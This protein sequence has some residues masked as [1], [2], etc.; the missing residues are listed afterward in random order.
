MNHETLEIRC[1]NS[2]WLMIYGLKCILAVSYT[3]LD[4]A[5]PDIYSMYNKYALT[6]ISQVLVSYFYFPKILNSIIEIHLNIYPIYLFD[7]ELID[8]KW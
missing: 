8:H 3:L 4:A 2:G 1:C 5:L 7:L 6:M